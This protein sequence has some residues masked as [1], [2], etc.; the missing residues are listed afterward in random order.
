MKTLKRLEELLRER[1]LF[2]AERAELS[3]SEPR[4]SGS[5]LARRVWGLYFIGE[6]QKGTFALGVLKVE[7]KEP[8]SFGSTTVDLQKSKAGTMGGRWDP[9][10]G[11]FSHALSMPRT[12]CASLFDIE[13]W[14]FKCQSKICDRKVF[15]PFFKYS[16]G[17]ISLNKQSTGMGFPLLKFF[18]LSIVTCLEGE[19]ALIQLTRLFFHSNTSTLTSRLTP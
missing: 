13:I 17:C 19:V 4:L 6:I 3:G 14:G 10:R 11:A 12:V 18:V 9:P 2:H 16:E 8:A 15:D 5:E 7:G 1:E